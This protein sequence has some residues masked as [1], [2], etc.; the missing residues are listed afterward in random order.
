MPG[1]TSRHRNQVRPEPP[2]RSPTHQ[3]LFYRGEREYLDGVMGFLR[4]ALEA[5][6]PVT[7]A[8]PPERGALL[9][10]E[11]GER[12]DQIEILDALELGRNPA[13]IIPAVERL[14]A[15]HEGSRL[16]YVGE[17]MWPGRSAEEI[18]EVAKHEALTNLAW[19]GAP[20]RILCPYD[21]D[22]LPPDILADAERTHPVV[23]ERGTP[24]RTESYT[25]GSV[26]VRCDQP[27][28][29][30]PEEA[31]EFAFT[32]DGLHDA[33]GIVDE[34]A[35]AA[36][37]DRTRVED[38]VL[39]VS[40]LAANAI[41]HG[42]GWGTLRVWRRPRRLICQVED[43]GTIRDPLAGR[44]TPLPLGAGG[45]GLW[46]VNQLCDLVEVRSAEGGTKI[47]LHTIID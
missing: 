22:R 4:P 2:D 17:P 28:P 15:Q 30:V 33:R 9:Q 38:L 11:L 13:R 31:V 27:L 40:E 25:G 39:A 24:R 41:R 47:R 32:I 7:A 10:R 8:I 5:G 29:P 44:R 42:R 14:L 21:A 26:P 37:L 12:A 20:I 6:E 3:A 46:A 18:R 36:G 45:I 19:P 43:G 34:E 16:H 35:T 1:I 23:I